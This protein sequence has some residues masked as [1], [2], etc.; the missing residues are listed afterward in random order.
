MLSLLL[1][2]P[3]LRN[4]GQGRPA[5]D[6]EEILGKTEKLN[7]IPYVPAIKERV[8]CNTQHCWNRLSE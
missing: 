8:K 3:L 7:S 5:E 4:P 6:R 1:N 2:G